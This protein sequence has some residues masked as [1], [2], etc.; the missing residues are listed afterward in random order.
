MS[1]VLAVSK[2]QRVITEYRNY[3]LPMQFPLVFLTG[4]HWRIS[5]VP[6]KRL[7]FHNCLEIGFCHTDGGQMVF[8]GQ[9]I[10]FE[11]GDITVVPRNVPHTTYSTAGT[12]S[13]WTYIFFDPKAMFDHYLPPTWKNHDLLPFDFEQFRYLFKQADYPQLTEML[14]LVMRE[15]NE[16]KPDYELSCRSLLLAF[17]IEIH[18]IL[19]DSNG[20]SIAA[21]KQQTAIDIESEFETATYQMDADNTSPGYMMNSLVI[22]PALEYVENN[23]MHQFSTDYLADLC[24]W[25]PTHFRRVFSEIMG[26]SPLEYINSTRILKSCHLLCNSEDSILNISSRVGFQSVSTY[27]RAFAKVME[28]SPRDYRKRMLSD[29]NTASPTIVEYSGWMVPEDLRNGKEH[30]SQDMM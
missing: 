21:S 2:Q 30:L 4:D 24:H 20:R 9:K 5:D 19:N 1:E 8:Y 18:R 6:S 29:P 14:T 16:Q 23:Y 10:P 7:H 13:R 12:Q 15:L 3:Y 11:A 17:Y 27:N 25:S 28:L 26:T 22:A